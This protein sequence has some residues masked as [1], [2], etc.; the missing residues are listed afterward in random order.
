[1]TCQPLNTDRVPSTTLRTKKCPLV[2]LAGV[3]KEL[4]G[5]NVHRFVKAEKSHRPHDQNDRNWDVKCTFSTSRAQWT[6]SPSPA[7][8]PQV[9]VNVSAV[10]LSGSKVCLI[11]IC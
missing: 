1:M 3:K 5:E 9:S 4:D 10:I 11:F 7:F 2:S 8:I 6:F